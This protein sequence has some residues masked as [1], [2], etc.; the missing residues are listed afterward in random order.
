MLDWLLQLKEHVDNN[1]LAYKFNSNKLCD[2]LDL[3]EEEFFTSIIET[4]M[5]NNEEYRYIK[6]VYQEKL[7][8]Q[9][10]GW[11][12]A[13][14]HSDSIS[15]KYFLKTI[16]HNVV[17]YQEPSD[18]DENFSSDDSENSS[19]ILSETSDEE[20]DASSSEEDTNS[21]SSYNISSD[22]LSEDSDDSHFETKCI[23]EDV[24]TLEPYK[25]D[26]GLF[27]IKTRNSQGKFIKGFCSTI[28]E[29]TDYLKAD[30]ETDGTSGHSN[31]LM[32]IW[33]KK[34]GHT[35]DDS[36]YGGYCSNKIVVK[37]P[38]GLYITIG[39]MEK[40]LSETNRVWYALPLYNGLRR[41]L[42]NL[43]SQFG[44]GMNHGQI[45]GFVVYKLFTKEEITQGVQVEE[46]QNDY[47]I[48]LSFHT[49]V[50]KPQSLQDVLYTI[51]SPS[52]FHKGLIASLCNLPNH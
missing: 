28:Q 25:S 5:D 1:D 12:N 3:D 20:S 31:I 34:K 7:Y 30:L 51:S 45:P 41:R 4:A 26:P 46:T 15:V 16:A 36:G 14:P 22:T 37:M 39:S 11:C 27:T 2:G 13:F 47:P 10:D 21:I 17:N 29:M 42:G 40:I 23:N 6:P 50:N 33:T 35:L 9:Q 43:E 49:L 52:N 24:M 32:G 44:V 38:F 48:N 19:D 8:I 18:S